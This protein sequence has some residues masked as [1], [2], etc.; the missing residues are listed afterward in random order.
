M[1]RSGQH[2]QPQG[3]QPDDR[4]QPGDDKTWAG[5]QRPH[6][7]RALRLVVAI[8]TILGGLGLVLA[9]MELIIELGPRQADPP[10]RVAGRTL[11]VHRGGRTGHPTK[12]PL[13][14]TGRDAIAWSF[15]CPPGQSGA[16]S[17]KDHPGSNK[18]EVSRSGNHAHGVWL[19]QHARPLRSLYVVA[20]CDWT[21]R[22]VRPRQT[23][24]PAPQ[25]GHRATHKPKHQHKVHKKHK[26]PIKAS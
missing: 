16:F 11:V 20:A 6:G 21:A 23:R 19:D 24:G 10:K 14:G 18:T 5:W 3:R 2:R 15:R 12:I 26:R 1:P 25:P 22:V 7:R 17:L 9:T 4:A 8:G 13:P